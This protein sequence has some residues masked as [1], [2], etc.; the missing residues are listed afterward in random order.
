MPFLLPA[1]R[2]SPRLSRGSGSLLPRAAQRAP[3]PE[4]L[5][6][7]PRRASGNPLARAPDSEPPSLSPR[8]LSTP[9]HFYGSRGNVC[10]APG[11]PKTSNS[12]KG[13]PPSASSHLPLPPRTPPRALLKCQEPPGSCL[14]LTWAPC[15]AAFSEGRPPSTSSGQHPP[16]GGTPS[17]R[18]LFRRL[19]RGP[20]RRIS[21][22]FPGL[23]QTPP[24][25]GPFPEPPPTPVRSPRRRLGDCPL[26]P[27]DVPC[28]R[29][30]PRSASPGAS[31]GTAAG[32]RH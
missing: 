4:A 30:S 12:T 8:H 19:P 22:L 9:R 6:R 13:N 14:P 21:G 1:H 26:P 29:T 27:R 7:F 11:P 16:K 25:R 10:F 28:P 23:C 32:L 3:L 2:S 17:S 18:N 5:A 31:R 15:A 20:P 24:F